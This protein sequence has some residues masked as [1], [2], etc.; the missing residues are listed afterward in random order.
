MC[1]IAGYIGSQDIAPDNIRRCLDAMHHRGPDNAA[2]KKWALPGSQNKVCL[3][4]TRLSIIDLDPRANQ[5]LN[6][7]RKW[8]VMNGE[9]YNYSEIKKSL[10]LKGHEFST[11][12]DCE[13]MVQALDAYGYLVLDDCE[14]MWA[15]AVYD[16]A[17]GTLTLCRDRFGEKPLYIF[18]DGTGFYFGSEIKFIAALSGKR[19]EVNYMHLLRYLISGYRALYKSDST[20][21]LDVTEVDPATRITIS[22]DL[23][24]TREV[25]WKPAYSPDPAMTYDE[26]VAGARERLIRSVELRLR[27][28]VPLA[29]CMSGGVDSN[30]LI[31]IARRVF[32]YDVHGFTIINKDPKYDERDVVEASVRTLGISHTPIPV[33]TTGFLENLRRLVRQHDAPVYTISYYAQWLLMKSIGEH[34]YRVSISGTA[35]D[36]M[37]SGYY[38]HHLMYLYELRHDPVR[39]EAAT[40]EWKEHVLP[41]VRNRHLRNERLFFDNPGFRDHLFDE[42]EVFRNYLVNDWWEDFCE[43]QYTDDLLRNRMLNEMFHEVIPVILHEDDLN[44]MSFSIENRSPFLDRNLFEFCFTIPTSHLIRDGAAKAILRDAMRGIVPDI[45]LDQRKKVGFNAPIFSFLDTRDPTVKAELL[46]PSPIFEII[47]KDKIEELLDKEE[48]PNSES[49]FLF[50]FLNA[51]IFLEEFAMN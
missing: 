20:F 2:Y 15:F 36:E 14:G 29:F 49:K 11:T 22:S 34:G 24:T 28:D 16:E 51:K 10:E 30:S 5:P 19:L 26:A 44:A 40:H 7:G 27:A 9:L 13:V 43:I 6:A 47:R 37:F 41:V 23:S 39:L 31:S 50:N 35:A 18:R 12:G 45:V 46:R 17:D 25:Y 21:F 33:T 32:H 38:D 4:H 3:L 48:L 1:G 8:L 42:S